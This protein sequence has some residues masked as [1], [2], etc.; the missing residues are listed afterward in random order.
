MPGSGTTSVIIT[1]KGSIIAVLPGKKENEQNQNLTWNEVQ[2]EIPNE[3]RSEK[4]ITQS[5]EN[6]DIRKGKY[7]FSFMEK[8]RI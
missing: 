8:I 1:L 6:S 2:N 7:P 3:M 5:L 4:P